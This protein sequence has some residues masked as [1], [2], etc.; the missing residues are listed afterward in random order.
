MLRASPP[1]TTRKLNIRPVSSIFIFLSTK[2]GFFFRGEIVYIASDNEAVEVS[3]AVEQQLIACDMKVSWINLK[4]FD[5]SWAFYFAHTKK[6]SFRFD[7]KKTRSQNGIS[8][9]MDHISCI[10]DT[11]CSWTGHKNVPADDAKCSTLSGELADQ[12]WVFEGSIC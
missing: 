11:P 4:F 6:S 10:P 5:K 7:N 1:A 9:E 12:N 8:R 2:K 3:T